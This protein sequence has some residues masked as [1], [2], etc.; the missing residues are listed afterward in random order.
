MLQGLNSK[1]RRL[2]A[3]ASPRSTCPGPTGRSPATDASSAQPADVHLGSWT[4]H[5]TFQAR[6][7]CMFSVRRGDPC[8]SAP[9]GIAVPGQERL[10]QSPGHSR[11]SGAWGYVRAHGDRLCPGA[12][13]ENRL[14]VAAAMPRRS[15]GA[16]EV[17]G[18]GPMGGQLRLEERGSYPVRSHCRGLV[19]ASRNPRVL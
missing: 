7:C 19:R 16:A 18:R 15:S 11:V 10:I 12:A 4:K 13:W 3:S 17:S 8:S 6:A 2:Q 5:G 9:L 1:H 14:P